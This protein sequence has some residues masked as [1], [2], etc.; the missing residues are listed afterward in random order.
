MSVDFC[1]ISPTP[2]LESF[3]ATNGAHLI[4]AHLV[5][6]DPAYADFYYNL[7]DGKE[8]I[9]DNS[10]FEMYKQGRPM[11]D[12]DKLLDMAR[13]CDADMIVMSDYPNESSEKTIAAAKETADI[14]HQ[15]GFETFY[16]PQSSIGDLEDYIRGIEWGLDNR[17]YV[18]RIGLSI[19]ACPNAYGVEKGNNLQRYLSR[20][21]ILKELEYRMILSQIHHK[22]IFHCL[23]MVDGPNEIELL[24]PYHHF[25]KTWDSS[26][27]VWAGLNGIRFDNSP[28]GLINGKF[29]KEVDFSHNESLSSKTVADVLYNIRYI[30]KMVND[31]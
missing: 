13:K 22:D 29:E 4:L 15:K 2:Y 9:M 6:E 1:H 11:Y 8:K 18:D 20:Y 3:T 16:V 25:I 10:A 17:E 23:G 14:Y 7:T 30:D 5:E 19:L 28:T 26:A 21:A 31:Y 24:R 12:T 27:A